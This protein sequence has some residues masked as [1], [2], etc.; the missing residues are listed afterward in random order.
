MVPNI[1]YRRDGLDRPGTSKQ[2]SNAGFSQVICSS[3]D[4]GL[5]TN[6]RGYK[7][8]IMRTGTY[9]TELSRFDPYYTSTSL[10]QTGRLQHTGKQGT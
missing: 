6:C 4:F 2:S 7:T 9:L 1:S 5:S 10:A 3:H 8:Q